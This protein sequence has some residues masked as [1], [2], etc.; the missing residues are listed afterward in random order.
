MKIFF[1]VVDKTGDYEGRST[2]R[3]FWLFTIWYCLLY[4]AFLVLEEVFSNLKPYISS[5]YLLSFVGTY[6]CLNNRRLHDSGRSGWWQLIS[7][8]PLVGWAFYVYFMVQPS[9]DDNKYGSKIQTDTQKPVAQQ[10]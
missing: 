3:E 1:D 8:I 9:D 2:R 7:L 5:L 10:A 4:F 6:I